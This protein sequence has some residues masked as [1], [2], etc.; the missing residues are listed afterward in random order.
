MR[1]RQSRFFAALS[2]ARLLPRRGSSRPGHQ[3][4]AVAAI[5]LGDEARS[6]ADRA[7]RRRATLLDAAVPTPPLARRFA[8]ALSGRWQPM[9][10]AVLMP[11]FAALFGWGLLAKHR[12][13]NSNG[14]DLAWFDQI[15]WNTAHG[16]PFANSFAPWNFLG[17]HVEPILLLFG[18]L[19]HLQP[20]VEILLLTQVLVATGAALP[21]YIGVRGLLGSSTAG[22]L[23]AAAFL[24]SP[25]L[26]NAMMFDFHPE[27]MGVASIFGAFACLVDRRPGWALVAVG[28]AFLLKE[29]AAL[30]ALGFAWLFWRHGHRRHAAGL[31]AAAAVYLVVVTA[32][33][34]PAA[35]DGVA[36]GPQARWS[37]LGD[38]GFEIVAGAVRHPD[39]VVHHLSETGPRGALVRLA[40]T[41]ALL[42]LLSPAGLIAAPLTLAHVLSEHTEEAELNLHYGVLPAALALVAAAFGART[43]AS[44]YE[45]LWAALR[46]EG[47]SRVVVL[48]AAVLTTSLVAAW[49][50]GPFGTNFIASHYQPRDTAADVRFA[51]GQIPAGASVAAQSGIL[52]HVSQRRE[53]WEF[54]PSADAEYVIVD[55]EAWRKTHG[56]PLPEYDYD[57]ALAALPAKGYCLLYQRGPVEVWTIRDC[58]S[59]PG[60]VEQAGRPSGP[61]Q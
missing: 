56:P 27:V 55:R 38:S 48:G 58:Q 12:A 59:A 60:P 44:R 22:L 18:A 6:A 31:A 47:E 23:F 5:P 26:A 33:V 29:D 46:L 4:V 28:S 16:R 8:V 39:R 61:A 14:W 40:G 53:V 21:L 3:H 51:I 13:F 24:V 17:E 20:R 43:L 10:L 42:P 45:P 34:M 52:P 37:Y 2:G 32:F 1:A 49:S 7:P 9:A 50:S 11:S 36:G 57:L 35:R 15:A 19:Y 30:V 41:H 25:F 54:P